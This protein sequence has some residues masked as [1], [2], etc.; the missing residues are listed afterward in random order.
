MRRHGRQSV[1]FATLACA[2]VCMLLT[3]SSV[4]QAQRRVR[5]PNNNAG[6][7]RTGGGEHVP[8]DVPA[9]A[10][11]ERKPNIILILTDDQDVELGECLCCVCLLV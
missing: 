11:K 6:R 2:C 5:T 4:V 3:G 7:T 9:G 10:P 1:L 8:G